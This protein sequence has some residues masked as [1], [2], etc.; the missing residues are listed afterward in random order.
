MW[1]V[2]ALM[3]L[4]SLAMAAVIERRVCSKVRRLLDRTAQRLLEKLGLRQEDRA[5]ALR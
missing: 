4:V 1:T 3:L 5:T 2:L